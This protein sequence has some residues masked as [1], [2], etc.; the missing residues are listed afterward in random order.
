[1]RDELRVG[2]DGDAPDEST[3]ALVPGRNGSL[4]VRGVVPDAAA[5]AAVVESV[6]DAFPDRDVQDALTVG[7]GAAGWQTSIE[8]LIPGLGD[9]LDPGVS[10]EPDGDGGMV[11]LRG[12]IPSEAARTRVEA[13]AASAVRA[14]YT[15]RSE[16][17]VD[18]NDDAGARNGE[19]VTDAS[20]TGDDRVAAPDPLRAT[21][22]PPRPR[23]ETPL[24]GGGV[25]FELATADLTS[26][27]RGV[28]DRVAAVLARYPSLRAEVQGHT[29]S[30][31]LVRAQPRPQPA[32][33]GD[34]P[35]VSE[36][37]GHRRRPPDGARLRRRS[38]DRH[39]RHREGARAQPPR[40][41]PPPA[42]GR[43]ARLLTPRLSRLCSG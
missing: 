21:C 24:A 4:V 8:S 39:E 29:D 43:L 23:S 3:F 38:A 32:A 31:R 7:P 16:L 17:V 35:R 10:V 20:S 18:T 19:D 6:R 12:R 5:R 22:K 11:V 27:S 40:R 28:L 1:M 37:G 41:L 36:A 15:L 13:A 34:R 30:E 14:P 26:A 42:L 9:V 25:E 2:G 33:G